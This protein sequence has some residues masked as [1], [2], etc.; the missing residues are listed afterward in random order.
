[1]HTR[2]RLLLLGLIACAGVGA[3]ACGA[4]DDP[5]LATQ[6][7]AVTG[8]ITISG[9]V[10]D[11]SGITLGDIVVTLAGSSTGKATTNFQGQYSFTVAPGSYSVSASGFCASFQPNVANLNN[12]TANA[13]QNFVGSGGDNGCGASTFSG[14]TSGPLTISGQVTSAGH[15]VPG[16]KVTLAG[17][18]SAFRF[19]DQAGNYSFSVSAGSYSIQVTGACASFTPNVV[20]LNNMT[21]SKVQNFVGSGNCPVAP[22]ALCP[23]LDVGFGFSEPASCNIV[24]TPDCAFDRAVNWD[25]AFVDEFAPIIS[26]DCRFGNLFNGLTGTDV[27]NYLNELLN[28]GLYFFGCPATGTVTG[29]LAD[30]IVP[31]AL[32]G[33][34]FTSADLAGLNADYLAAVNQGLSDF[35]APPL[36]PAQEAAVSAQLTAVAARYTPQTNS[37][38]FTFSTCP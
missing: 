6:S 24:S 18:T 33:H 31:P 10:T 34:T 22:L 8:T 11:T 27:V 20:N 7:S 13:V 9:T 32:V 19:T 21:T 25:S 23:T 17:G 36:T 29:P 30:G 28:F 12:L 2:P 16:A 3:S 14:A 26:A 35:G 38:N 15:A 5:A 1:M 4:V 37:S